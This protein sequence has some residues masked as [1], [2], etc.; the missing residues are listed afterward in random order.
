MSRKAIVD[1][2]TKETLELDFLITCWNRLL[3]TA[4]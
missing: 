1:R 3:N 2:V 4:R